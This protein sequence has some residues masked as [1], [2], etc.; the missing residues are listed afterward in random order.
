MNGYEF[1]PA[2]SLMHGNSNTGSYH[3][4]PKC[5]KKVVVYCSVSVKFAF[6]DGED[7]NEDKN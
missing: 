5:E 6:E 3:K 1:Y 7:K 2:S 4:C